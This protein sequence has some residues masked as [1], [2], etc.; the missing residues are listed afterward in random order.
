MWVTPCVLQEYF[1][2]SQENFTCTPQTLVNPTRALHSHAVLKQQ[3]IKTFLKRNQYLYDCVGYVAYII[4]NFASH[5]WSWELLSRFHSVTMTSRPN[6]SNL[7]GLPEN[8]TW[9]S[10]LVLNIYKYKLWLYRTLACFSLGWHFLFRFT[11]KPEA[12]GL[13]KVRKGWIKAGDWL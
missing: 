2:A 13:S 7:L 8:L 9:L 1:S 12:C 3:G 5:P 6:G 11:S 10:T 4:D